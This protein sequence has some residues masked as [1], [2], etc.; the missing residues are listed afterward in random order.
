[1]LK[2]LYLRE[3]EG[4]RTRPGMVLQWIDPADAHEP[5]DYH[6]E[7]W[8]EVAE[9]MGYPPENL[10]VEEISL[11]SLDYGNGPRPLNLNKL[12]DLYEFLEAYGVSC[13][14]EWA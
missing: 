6:K 12:G 8:E 14:E 3:V 9:W 1:M 13:S 7:G 5:D 2:R 10:V 11:Q 4:D